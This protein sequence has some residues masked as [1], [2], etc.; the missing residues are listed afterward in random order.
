VHGGIARPPDAAGGSVSLK[1]RL[2]TL[3]CCVA[4]EFGALAGVPMRPEEIQNLMQ[5]LNRPKVAH[6]NPEKPAEGDK[7]EAGGPE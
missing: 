5:T 7:P 4:L 6:T 1:R 2:R 3:L